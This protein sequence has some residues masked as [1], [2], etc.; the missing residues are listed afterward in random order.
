MPKNNS[1]AQREYRRQGAEQRQ[2]EYDKLTREQK[3]QKANVA[4]GLA[5]RQMRRF[6]ATQ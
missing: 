3:F 2:A 1:K 5:L 6:A 4:P